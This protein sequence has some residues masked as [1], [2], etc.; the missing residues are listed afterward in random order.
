ME[1]GTKGGPHPPPGPDWP[2]MLVG[3]I[4]PKIMMGCSG[5]P[6]GGPKT[7]INFQRAAE[8]KEKKGKARRR[9]NF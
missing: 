4:I 1:R 6:E 5:G 3:S 8:K 9:G 7:R 2:G